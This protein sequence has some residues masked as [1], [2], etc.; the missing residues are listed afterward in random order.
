ML[1]LLF[2]AALMFGATTASR[3]ADI[4]VVSMQYSVEHPVP[5][6]RYEG[7]TEPGDLARLQAVYDSF[8]RCR[9]E[10]LSPDGGS[11]AVLSMSGPGGSYNEGLALAQY[12]R[13]NAIATVVQRGDT[14]ASACAFAYLGGSGYSSLPNL[15][16]YVDRQTEPGGGPAFHSPYF[17]E[18][19]ILAALEARGTGYVM[20]E[21][22]NALSL[23]VRELVQWN[24]DPEIIHEMVS[25]GPSETYDVLNGED[26]YLTRSALPAV[27]ATDWAADLPSAVRNA[28]MR[29]LAIDER[30]DP[31]AFV[32]LLD[33]AWQERLGVDE[34][35][36]VVSGF[37]WGNELLQVTACGMPDA[38]F[39][40]EMKIALYF[41][42]GM[43]GTIATSPVVF[44]N[45]ANGFSTAGGGHNPHKR[46]MQ[47]GQMNHF[48][49]PLGVPVDDLD[50]PGELSMLAN[51]FYLPLAPLM[52]T[53][54]P[55]MEV[56]TTGPGIRVTRNG[57]VWMFE[58]TGPKRLF[59]T[60]VTD[61]GRG[62]TL[63]NNGA[64]ASAFVRE[65]SYPDGTPFKWFGFASGDSALVTRIVLA[66][67]GGLP[68]TADEQVLMR[69]LMCRSEFQ[70]LKLGCG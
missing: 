57:D 41:S 54:D 20:D 4:F 17:Q 3:A 19:D 43:D 66:R 67:P 51:R 28:C 36:R 12:I 29:L 53:L 10:C 1:R 34:T 40:P 22:R 39:G 68:A 50:L 30:S 25:K 62:L 27:P 24:V 8:V 5:H 21:N 18:E 48:F 52:P 55:R 23:M 2:A 44:W 61:P 6:I 32:N 15:G 7:D 56:A 33:V 16:T 11:T 58:Q 65:G 35:G 9:L 13:A 45:R 14:C 38:G 63:T 69:Q 47:R 46:I 42:P 60:A 49:L 64:N 26:Y 31:R 70:G 37:R 59:D